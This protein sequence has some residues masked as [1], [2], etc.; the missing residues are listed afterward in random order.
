MTSTN[1]MVIAPR[2]LLEQAL[3]AAAAVGMQDVADELDRILTPKG[4]QHQGKPLE[5]KLGSISAVM[6][7]TCN[8]ALGS[9]LKQI[10]T[11]RAQLA[12]AR[13]AFQKVMNATDDSQDDGA[14]HKNAYSI[15]AHALN[16]MSAA[17]QHLNVVPRSTITDGKLIGH[18]CKDCGSRADLERK[19]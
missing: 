4:E 17:C 10:D 2:E 12:I 3:D 1:Q 16:D 19:S 14:H 11:L 18:F 7:D 9:A 6:L 15:A 8:T 5:D 13:A